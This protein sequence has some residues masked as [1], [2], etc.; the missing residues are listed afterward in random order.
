MKFVRCECK[1]TSKNVCCKNLFSRR[2]LGLKY[3]VACGDFKGES[4][5][6]SVHIIEEDYNE[7][8]I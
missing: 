8:Y 1:S 6:N 3:M 5:G 2:K 7:D 4:C